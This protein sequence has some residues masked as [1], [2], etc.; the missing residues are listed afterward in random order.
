MKTIPRNAD[1]SPR[2]PGP[3]LRMLRLPEVES[4]TGLK[5]RRIYQLEAK[6]EFPKHVKVS[7]RASAWMEHEIDAYILGKMAAR[8]GKPT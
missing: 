6:G 2:P 5:R 4:R 3:V 8:G 1:E 7:D